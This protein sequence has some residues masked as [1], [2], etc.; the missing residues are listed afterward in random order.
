MD[1]KNYRQKFKKE[2]KITKDQYLA[3]EIWRYFEKRLQFPRIM[4]II[5]KIGWQGVYEIFQEIKKSDAQNRLSLFIWKV[6]NEKV[7]WQ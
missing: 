3:D 2:K 1:I 5:K 6:K 7:I 4:I